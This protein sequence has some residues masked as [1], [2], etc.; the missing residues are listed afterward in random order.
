LV[1]ADSLGERHFA[2][3]VAAAAKPC[4]TV[5]LIEYIVIVLAQ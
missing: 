5:G 3:F 2:Q 4:Q 1:I